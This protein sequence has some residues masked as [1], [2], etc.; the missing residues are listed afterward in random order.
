MLM[1]KEA[2]TSLSSGSTFLEFN[3]HQLSSYEI[4]IPK[5]KAE[6]TAIAAV[7]SDMDAEIAALEA[8]RAKTQALKQGMMQDLL[9]GRIRLERETQNRVIRLFQKGLGYA[10]LGDLS[11]QANRPILTERLERH[12]AGR[13]YAPAQIAAALRQLAQAAEI[14]LGVSLYQVNRRT[15]NLLRYGAQVAV[16]VGQAHETVQFIDWQHPDANDFA[17]AEE[18]TL[19]DGSAGRRPDLVLYCNGLAVAVLELK[20]SAV[21]V[22]EGIRQQLSNQKDNPFFFS[23]V[24]LV[25]A[26]NDSQGLHYGTVGTPEQFFTR[27]KEGDSHR[28]T[29][30]GSLLDT[31]L[32]QMFARERLL[33]WLYDCV[34]FDGGIK[35]VPRPHQY[36]GL[37]AAQERLRRREGGVI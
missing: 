19:R 12:L 9:T 17:I 11:G 24:Q 25:L 14:P 29:G 30:S 4:C 6:Q 8:R 16:D 3:K 34:I 10:F 31:P 32:R 33:D 36:F 27:W 26:G 18:V 21:S 2:L 28:I 7:L 23:T 5:D 13:G 20:R 22:G 15:Y 1:Q 37:K 35:K